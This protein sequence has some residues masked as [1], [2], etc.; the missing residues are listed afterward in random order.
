MANSLEQ[1]TQGAYAQPGDNLALTAPPGGSHSDNLSDYRMPASLQS[2]GGKPG[3]S[4][5][6]HQGEKKHSGK[7]PS[8][9]G[10]EETATASNKTLTD[11]QLA[12]RIKRDENT[13]SLQYT[14]NFEDYKE[15]KLTLRQIEPPYINGDKFE[16]AYEATDQLS[17]AHISGIDPLPDGGVKIEYDDGAYETLKGDGTGVI[18]RPGLP[19]T[20]I[21]KDGSQVTQFDD[22]TTVT[23]SKKGDI[24]VLFSDGTKLHDKT[25]GTRDIEY[26]SGMTLTR[27]ETGKT[28]IKNGNTVTT[29]EPDGMTKTV[30]ESD[31]TTTYGNG[32]GLEWGRDKDGLMHITES[33]AGLQNIPD[34]NHEIHLDEQ[35]NGDYVMTV[36][37][38]SDQSDDDSSDHSSDKQ[39]AATPEFQVTLHKTTDANGDVRYSDDSGDLVL[40]RDPQT[41]E[42][43]LSFHDGD[44]TI[45]ST[46]H[47]NGTRTL[48]TQDTTGHS[49]PDGSYTFVPDDP[50]IS[51]AKFWKTGKTE[52]DLKNGDKET[53]LPTGVVETQKPGGKVENHLLQ[54]RVD[55]KNLTP[56]QIGKNIEVELP[57]G[58]VGTLEEGNSG[59]LDLKV[60]VNDTDYREIP[61]TADNWTYQQLDLWMS[62]A[63]DVPNNPL[64]N[65][66]RQ[67]N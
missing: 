64:I 11:A 9:P 5:A 60:K 36:M 31:H 41:H 1:P 33:S 3:G 32:H 8:K 47:D 20:K 37:P 48:S 26:G 45:L 17:K 51:Q 57:N 7:S 43:T 27:D 42:P 29:T 4:G 15:Q 58:E 53:F 16:K 28:V 49:N 62:I 25:D 19:D 54:I 44:D 21:M 55:G 65:V 63:E 10:A 34:T 13:G 52:L 35:K 23:R 50:E 2:K 40:S 30:D 66:G 56:W 39:A 38:V 67:S 6:D 12:A 61:V 59:E 14:H 24:T 18:H 22:G 46:V